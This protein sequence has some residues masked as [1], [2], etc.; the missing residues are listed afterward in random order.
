V[1]PACRLFALVL[2]VH[3]ARFLVLSYRSIVSLMR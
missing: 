2:A 1:V 3:P